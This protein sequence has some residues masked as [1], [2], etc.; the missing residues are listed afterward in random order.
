MS[1]EWHERSRSLKAINI[2]IKTNRKDLHEE[3][4]VGKVKAG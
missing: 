4:Q 3:A 2:L 1:P